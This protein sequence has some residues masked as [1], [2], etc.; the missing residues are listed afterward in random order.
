MHSVSLTVVGCVMNL[1][2]TTTL[3]YALEIEDVLAVCFG[4]KKRLLYLILYVFKSVKLQAGVVQVKV[5]SDHCGLKVPYYEK[6]HI[7]SVL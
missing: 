1:K 6:I 4:C 5:C 7:T 3:F 2:K